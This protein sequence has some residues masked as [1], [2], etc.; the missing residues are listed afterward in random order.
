MLLVGF[1]IVKVLAKGEELMVESEE[2]V[3]IKGNSLRTCPST[4]PLSGNWNFP[5]HFV[6]IEMRGA[7]HLGIQ[8]MARVL[9]FE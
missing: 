4:V 8:N 2:G 5:G 6:T 7:S 3:Q 1:R 9:H